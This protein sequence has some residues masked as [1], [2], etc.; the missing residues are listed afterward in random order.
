M[1]ILNILL[2]QIEPIEQTSGDEMDADLL[3]Q[4][5]TND[6]CPD[7]DLGKWVGKSSTMTAAQKSELMKKCWKPHDS[8]NFKD[9]AIDTARCFKQ[10]WLTTYA[11]WLTYSQKLKG[12]LCLNC[13]LFHRNVVQGVLGAFVVRPFTRYRN[14]HEA[15]RNHATSS[16]H[17]SATTA[18]NHFAK[19][20]PVDVLMQTG[21][22]KQIEQNREIIASIIKN[23]LTCGTNDLPLRG[24]DLDSGK[25][26]HRFI[27]FRYN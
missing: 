19:A 14:L 16:W 27:F 25:I 24:K 6:D 2:L 23:V 10:S 8:Y 7:F 4:S 15:C 21:H 12:A 20:K 11:P 3:A 18:A 17:I 13:V 26:L 5:E 9:D 1:R 22:E